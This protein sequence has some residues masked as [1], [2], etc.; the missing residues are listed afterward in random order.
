MLSG[1]RREL[2]KI[3]TMLNADVLFNHV[4]EPALQESLDIKNITRTEHT[5]LKKILHKQIVDASI[6]RDVYPNKSPG[7]ISQV[8]TR[9]KKRG[10]IASYPHSNSRKYIIRFTGPLLIRSLINALERAGYLP[11]GRA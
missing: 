2:T 11:I 1:L 5:T 8:I 7:I 6:F 3:D 4:L 9:Y 10:L